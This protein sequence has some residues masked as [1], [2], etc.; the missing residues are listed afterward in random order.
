MD[1]ISFDTME[2]AESVTPIK[3]PYIP[4]AFILREARADSAYNEIIDM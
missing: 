3:F 1:S 2:V 4:G